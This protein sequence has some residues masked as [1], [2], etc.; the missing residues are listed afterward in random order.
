MLWRQREGNG[1][2]LLVGANPTGVEQDGINGPDGILVGFG[3]T[4]ERTFSVAFVDEDN[5]IYKSNAN[6]FEN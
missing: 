1:F 6:G 5:A 3:E 4:V 2:L